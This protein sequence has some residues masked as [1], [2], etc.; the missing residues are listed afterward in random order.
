MDK[1]K[2]YSKIFDKLKLGLAVL[3]Q[4]GNFLFINKT[5]VEI[6]GYSKKELGHIEEWL[7]LA[8]PDEKIRSRTSQRFYREIESGVYSNLT[9]IRCKNDQEKYVELRVN[10]LEDGLLL[11][12]LLDR[13]ENHNLNKKLADK[14]KY[15][16]KIVSNIPEVIILLDEKQRFL[17]IWSGLEKELY[18]KKDEIIGKQISEIFSGELLKKL[19]DNLKLAEQT[20]QVQNFEYQLEM[21]EGLEDYAG[22]LLKIEKTKGNEFLL[23]SRNITHRVKKEKELAEIKERL[24]LAVDAANLGIWDW[25][26]KSDQIKNNDNFKEMV[27]L[28]AEKIA[29]E[30]FSFA[31]WES[32]VHPD[33][34]EKVKYLIA[35]HLQGKT[36]FYQSEH[37]IKT[38][39]G[40]WKWIKDRARVSEW[41]AEGNPV[42]MVGIDI[43]ID[44]RKREEQENIYLSAAMKNISDAVFLQNKDFEIIFMNKK[45]EELSGYS[46]EELKNKT[47]IQLIAGENAAEIQQKIQQKVAKGELYSGELK[48][49]R[50]DGSTFDGELKITPICTK[51]SKCNYVSILRDIS[52]RKM[53]IK[54]LKFQYRLENL[55]SKISTKFVGADQQ[56]LKEALNYSLEKLSLFLAADRS[57]IYRFEDFSTN[58]SKLGE[59]RQK[60]TIAQL[61]KRKVEQLFTSS[62][63]LEAILDKGYFYVSEV[64]KLSNRRQKKFFQEE[65]IKSSIYLG[66]FEDQK[67]LGFIAFDFLRAEKDLTDGYLKTLDIA[68]PIISNAIIKNEKERKIKNLTFRDNLTGL[69]NR[70][71]L[72]EEI[73]RLDRER[74]LPISVLISDINGL[75]EVNDKFGH[76]VG[77]KLIVK[78]A[79][80]LKSVFREEDIIARWGGDE[81]II[82]LPR[83]AKSEVEKMAERLELELKRTEQDEL[84][85]SA[86]IGT[87]V[88]ENPE[89]DIDLLINRADKAMYEDKAQKKL[90]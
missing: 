34:R 48:N 76:T 16:N 85:V 47:A 6:I 61:E 26:L 1:I 22:R 37:R 75:K 73:K 14:T 10:Q 60:Q 90:D 87:A 56:S 31:D 88:K 55:I 44:K 30:D 84:S 46:L 29:K 20:N 77:D 63:L 58:I 32:L 49:K 86:G 62:N 36:D 50:K 45:A 38:V 74:Q 23:V 42:R 59:W 43:D 18:R 81:F 68:A 4:E 15:L 5:A 35:E 89:E 27:G 40:K 65:S 39:S 12:N 69:Y 57:Y 54:K 2:S 83:T 21:E 51:N 66:L 53:R 25:N 67:L 79:E 13:T 3:D 7:E 80:I 9:K 19:R 33:D 52:A 71:F 17:D 41:D 11:V 8:Y 28:E 24:E 72:A 78:M 64:E 82:F 70:T